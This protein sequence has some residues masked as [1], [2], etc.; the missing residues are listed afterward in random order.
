MSLAAC[1][2]ADDALFHHF[3]PLEVLLWI[4]ETDGKTQGALVKNLEGLVA[5]RHEESA[6][7]LNECVGTTSQRGTYGVTVH[8]LSVVDVV[9]EGVIDLVGKVVVPTLMQLLAHRTHLLILLG[10][11]PMVKHELAGALVEE[12]V[13]NGT[14]MSVDAIGH[15]VVLPSELVLPLGEEA[16]F[17]THVI[18]LRSAW[19][20]VVNRLALTTYTSLKDELAIPRNL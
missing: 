6:I 20:H 15:K 17:G 5:L 16:T 9:A 10:G 18:G 7:S 1:I 4:G 19:L 2:E 12:V 14:T 13:T 3:L 11:I 8:A